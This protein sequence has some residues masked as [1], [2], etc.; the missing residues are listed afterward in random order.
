MSREST[1]RLEWLESLKTTWIGPPLTAEGFGHFRMTWNRKRNSI[2]DVVEVQVAT[3]TAGNRL[4]LTVNLGILNSEVYEAVWS[5]PVPKIIRE[6]DCTVKLRIGRLS[7]SSVNVH[8]TDV[9]WL[10]QD[11]LDVERTGTDIRRRIE[12]EVLPFFGACNSHGDFHGLLQQF[13]TLG[14]VRELGLI[15]QA[16]LNALLGQNARAKECLFEASQN[17][18]WQSR[19]LVAKENLGL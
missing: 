4:R 12:N 5:Q 18:A 2:V 13:P 1:H 11:G 7:G 14:G 16:A 17:S 15:Y 3:P 10:L 9:W 6:A 19:A 8:A